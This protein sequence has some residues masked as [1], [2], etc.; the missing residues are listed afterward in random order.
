MVFQDP[1]GSLNSASAPSSI[2]RPRFTALTMRKRGGA[3][4]SRSS[5]RSASP[6]QPCS[7]I[8]TNSPAVNGN[9]SGS[10]E[11]SSC[12]PSLWFATNRY[13]RF[14]DPGADSQSAG[15]S[16]ERFRA[17]LSLHFSR[18][19][20]GS[21]FCR[22]RARECIS[23]ASSKAP[24]TPP[25][26]ATRATP[27]RVPCWRRFRRRNWTRGRQPCLP[28]KPDRHSRARMPVQGALSGGS[29][30]VRNR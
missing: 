10:Q 15:R 4:F 16:Q 20:G 5:A 28:G 21:L 22:S 17:R 7:V 25:C 30:A 8:H 9:E 23:A 13:A 1:F 26:G 2:R 27:I 14:L 18:S 19:V 12:A 24:T 29:Q 3:G 11:R 6:R